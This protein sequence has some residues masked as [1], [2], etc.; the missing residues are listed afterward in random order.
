MGIDEIKS[1]NFN[2]KNEE[3]RNIDIINFNNYMFKEGEPIKEITRNDLKHSPNICIK[4]C[5]K[6]AKKNNE[7]IFNISNQNNQNNKFLVSTNTN[8]CNLETKSKIRKNKKVSFKNINIQ[9]AHQSIEIKG[10]N[11]IPNKK[12]N[13]NEDIIKI[14]DYFNDI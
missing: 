2:H 7:L 12:D 11:F 5:Q 14:K 4:I 3:E 9:I 6:N 1:S 8:N 13:Q 10:G